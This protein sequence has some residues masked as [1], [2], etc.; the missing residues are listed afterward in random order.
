MTVGPPATLYGLEL[1]PCDVLVLGFRLDGRPLTGLT[2]RVDWRCGGR[3]SD[4]VRAG[5]IPA[6]G[7]L[8]L[9][10]FPVVPA[11]RLVLWATADVTL[12]NL[13]ICLKNLRAQR[14]GLCP[15]DLGLDPAATRA[16]LGPQAVLFSPSGEPTE[17]V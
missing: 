17:P 6:H 16:T 13:S 10:A 2:G 3:L 15:A 7:P 8:L 11:S 4:L 1:V 5:V 12:D 14:P 9:P